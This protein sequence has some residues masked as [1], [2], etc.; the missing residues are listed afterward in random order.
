MH[1]W[2]LT[3]RFLEGVTTALVYSHLTE[4]AGSGKFSV[5]CQAVF[6]S[7]PA[8]V[9]LGIVTFIAKK[10]AGWMRTNRGS[11][12]MGFGVDFL[13][14][15]IEVYLDVSRTPDSAFHRHRGVIVLGSFKASG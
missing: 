2:W 5:A 12:V 13:G 7:L 10:F 14:S 8:I 9:V 1:F 4:G 11:G 15:I 3:N 6:A